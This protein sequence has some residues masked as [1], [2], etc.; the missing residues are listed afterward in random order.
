MR[1]LRT[2]YAAAAALLFVMCWPSSGGARD[3]DADASVSA[4]ADRVA[5]QVMAPCCF[6]NTVAE[7]DSPVSRRVRVEIVEL[8]EG[9]AS[10]QAVLDELVRRYGERIL[11]APRTN[12]FGLLAYLVPP[13]ALLVASAVIARFVRATRRRKAAA[14]GVAI[15][16][17]GVEIDPE[18]RARLEAELADLDGATAPVAVRASAR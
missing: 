5:R 15:E 1:G 8:L 3:A 12:G 13:L 2:P 16:T 11:A 18:L 10:E 17:R 14:D 7:H 4:A 9:G 6:V